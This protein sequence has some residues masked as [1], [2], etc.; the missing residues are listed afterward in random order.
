MRASII[1]FLFHR[2]IIIRFDMVY[3]QRKY[4][5]GLSISYLFIVK[6]CQMG[7]PGPK[8]IK[9]DRGYRGIPGN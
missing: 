3:S 4:Y 1:C 5:Y 8:G 6:V 2:L 7:F 9:G